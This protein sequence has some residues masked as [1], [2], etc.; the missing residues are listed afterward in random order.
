MKLTGKD[1][2][3]YHYTFFVLFF[4]FVCFV[5]LFCFVL[6]FCKLIQQC[7]RR[8]VSPG[9]TV[10]GDSDTNNLPIDTINIDPVKL[11]IDPATP[12]IDTQ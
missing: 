11:A 2:N 4:C 5:C 9:S 1:I 3:V 6:F 8:Y 12:A 10:Y 7:Y